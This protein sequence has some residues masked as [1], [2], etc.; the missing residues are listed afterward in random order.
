MIYMVMEKLHMSWHEIMW[1]RSWINIVLMIADSPKTVKKET[2]VQK[3]TGREMA[4]RHAQ[5][6]KNNG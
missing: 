3:A 4:E 1:K 6:H 5:K 2:V